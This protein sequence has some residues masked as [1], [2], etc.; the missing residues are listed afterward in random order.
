MDQ[1]IEMA[2]ER[3]VQIHTSTAATNLVVDGGTVVGVC[4]E[5]PAARCTTA[6][7]RRCSSWRAASR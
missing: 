7:P 3:G 5:G 4:A 1:I 2:T 6:A